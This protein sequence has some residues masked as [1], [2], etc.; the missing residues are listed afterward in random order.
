MSINRFQAPINLFNKLLIISL[1]FYIP[2]QFF[3]RYFNFDEYQN[4]FRLFI[5]IFLAYLFLLSKNIIKIVVLCVLTFYI[6]LNC[7]KSCIY[8]LYYIRLYYLI[9]FYINLYYAIPFRILYNYDNIVYNKTLSI[10]WYD[11][12]Y[13]YRIFY[14]LFI[15][16]SRQ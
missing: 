13:N 5:L 4:I 1:F 3:F 15:H 9:I 16:L 11:M 2:F 14:K 10:L 6:L 7:I 12:G 8:V